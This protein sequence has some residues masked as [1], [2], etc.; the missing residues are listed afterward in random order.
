MR[1][2]DQKNLIGGPGN[3]LLRT[4]P[5][6]ASR[7]EKVRSITLFFMVL[8]M[9]QF[10]RFQKSVST[11]LYELLK[12][13]ISL[14]SRN[15]IKIAYWLVASDVQ[16]PQVKRGAM[17]TEFRPPRASIP[18]DLPGPERAKVPK[19]K[20]EGIFFREASDWPLRQEPPQQIARWLFAWSCNGLEAAKS[21]GQPRVA[22]YTRIRL[23]SV[24]RLTTCHAC[25]PGVSSF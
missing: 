18:R 11:W 24:G 21:R 15:G 16:A 2:T 22:R 20:A 9:T 19:R 8:R 12:S 23:N 1:A 5:K 7:P 3:S 13:L 25:R 14:S 17:R 10:E 6:V 4:L